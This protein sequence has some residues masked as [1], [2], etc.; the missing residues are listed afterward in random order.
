MDGGDYIVVNQ[1]W[2]DMWATRT[3]AAWPCS[4][5][6]SKWAMFYHDGDG[7]HFDE[8]EGDRASIDSHEAQAMA[9]DIDDIVREHYEEVSA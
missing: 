6:R 4:T 7:W 1:N 3:G 9:D 2:T 8:C 5:L